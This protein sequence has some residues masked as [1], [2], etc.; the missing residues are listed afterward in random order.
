MDFN[1]SGRFYGLL[2]AAAIAYFAVIVAAFAGLIPLGYWHD[3]YMTFATIRSGGLLYSAS[4]LMTW[5]PRPVSDL[6][7]LI[8]GWLAVTMRGE[9]MT[10]ALAPVWL[11]LFVCT[12]VSPFVFFRHA[13]ATAKCA[14][15]VL[16]MALMCSFLLGHPV[17]EAFYFPMAAFAYLPTLAGMTILLWSLCAGD[18][19]SRGGNVLRGGA[20]LV[21]AWSS[22][23]GAIFTFIF[24]SMVMAVPVAFSLLRGRRP[25]FRF[26]KA[27][28]AVPLAGAL[29]MLY[30]VA[31]GR[32]Q[33]AHEGAG[34]GNDAVRHHALNALL[35]TGP[36]FDNEMF[37][38]GTNIAST[39]AIKVLFLTGAYLIL[40]LL[41]S[42]PLKPEHREAAYY[43]AA[44]AIAA[45]AT[46]FATIAAAFYQYGMDC[47][48]HHVTTRQDL[49]F[50]ALIAVAAVPV[51]RGHGIT[52]QNWLRPA[53]VAC[54]ALAV[55]IPMHTA[56]PALAS[57]YMIY[58]T[59][60]ATKIENWRAGL[61]PAPSMNFVV[62][63]Q[64]EIVGGLSGMDGTFKIPNAP[65][66]AFNTGPFLQLDVALFFNKRSITFISAGQSV[67]LADVGPLVRLIDI[68]R[69]TPVKA[70]VKTRAAVASGACSLN[71][72]GTQAPGPGMTVSADD[73]VPIS[74]WAL[75]NGLGHLPSAVFVTLHG[76]KGDFS[77]R[78]AKGDVRTDV[79]AY[80]HL[81]AALD[82]S[83]FHVNADFSRVPDG[84][85]QLS[86]R[87]LR[88]HWVQTCGM[89]PLT[90]QHAKA[91]R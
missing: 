6:L 22:E 8:Y 83:G 10:S 17:A 23:I 70:S 75:M 16:A 7:V 34:F 51:L 87:A 12:A 4:V 32:A 28:L 38:L 59:I 14:L 24:A 26:I 5:I 91:S 18:T 62:P 61:S 44:L 72:I 11:L 60:T 58:D 80:F 79:T 55:T 56:L 64:G 35:A 74:G 2:C 57:N 37:S 43:L 31:T 41:P 69:F 67:A 66:S 45:V 90:V 47:C 25:S 78:T 81:P 68:A 88:G 13:T 85:Y 30:K 71:P 52:R 36:G 40:S 42:K 19:R 73:V 39:M 9:M 15:G 48:E 54:L 20:L 27:W 50:I 63:P 65:G 3:E 82:D 1:P 46:F 21:A 86:I 53:G 89:F 76:A 77:V 49:I 29:W 84:Q 33:D